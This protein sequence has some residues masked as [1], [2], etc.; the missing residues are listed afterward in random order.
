[1]GFHCRLIFSYTGI[2]I[3]AGRSKSRALLAR[4]AK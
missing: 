1:M 4:L 3:Q 2:F